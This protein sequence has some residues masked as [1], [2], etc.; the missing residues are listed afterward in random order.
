MRNSN[1]KEVYVFVR[2]YQQPLEDLHV[3]VRMEETVV[4]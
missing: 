3:N 1:G 4:L 2:K